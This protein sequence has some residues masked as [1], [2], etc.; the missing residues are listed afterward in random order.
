MPGYQKEEKFDFFGNIGMV[1]G[2]NIYFQQDD[3]TPTILPASISKPTAGKFVWEITQ[4]F[5]YIFLLLLLC[6][7]KLVRKLVRML[8][9]K[10]VSQVLD[11]DGNVDDDD[12]ND[13]DD[14]DND[15]TD[16]CYSVIITI[17]M[18]IITVSST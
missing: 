12:G 11:D 5:I 14:D 4:Y 6:V 8:I 1:F 16:D 17:I 9:R 3:V 7:R 13:D 10:Y 2:G 18:V 15:D